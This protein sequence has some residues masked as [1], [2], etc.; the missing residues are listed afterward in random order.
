MADTCFYKP[1]EKSQLLEEK[2]GTKN[3]FVISYIGAI[4]YANG[5]EF[6]LHC[7]K[8]TQE[9]SIAL[10]FLVCGDGAMLEELKSLAKKLC[11]SNVLFIPFKNRDG[12]NE[13]MRVTDAVFVCYKRFSILETGSPNKYFD[14][15]A[16][17]K[18]I[19]I[20]FG[21]W[22]RKEIELYQC[23]IYIDD[24]NNLSKGI[25]P[26]IT[27]HALLRQFQHSARN[28]AERKYSRR[29]LSEKFLSVV[30]GKIPD[31]IDG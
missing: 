10:K 18:L 22:I 5:L 28:L 16:A 21:G 2:Y 9:A 17:G 23:G 15:L 19:V 13:L 12:V 29:L 25:E 1:S 20:N 30:T 27:N 7:A 31:P 24:P 8:T 26:F 4:G 14:G 11:L 6:L 3:C